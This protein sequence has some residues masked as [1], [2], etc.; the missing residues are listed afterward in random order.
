MMPFFS[1]D[2]KWIGFVA[3]GQLKKM[4]VSGGPAETLCPAVNPDGASW[5]PNESI[6]FGTNWG[7]GLLQVSVRGGNPEP[8]A[9]LN[10]A[11]GEI[12]HKDPHIL[13]D[14]SGVLFTSVGKQGP[15]IEALVPGLGTAGY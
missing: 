6:V 4:P 14:G 15:R 7:S 5:G 3:D 8:L 9:T 12:T 2:G 11:A 1:P 13:P 10:T